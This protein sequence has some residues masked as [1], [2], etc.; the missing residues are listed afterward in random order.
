L[1][2]IVLPQRAD[3]QAYRMMQMDRDIWVV[4]AHRE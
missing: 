1:D 3:V 2:Q 4:P